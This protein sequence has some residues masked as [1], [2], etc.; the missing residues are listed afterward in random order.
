MG[1]TWVLSAPGG[2]HVGPMNLA[3][4]AAT[5]GVVT[6]RVSIKYMCYNTN[7]SMKLVLGIQY[8]HAHTHTHTCT[9]THIHTFIWT[10]VAS[11]L[12]ACI[13]TF[14]N[15]HIRIEKKYN[16]KR[17][18]VYIVR[19]KWNKN[20]VVIS[21]ILIYPGTRISIIT[22]L[23]V[24][25]PTRCHVPILTVWKPY[26]GLRGCPESSRENIAFNTITIAH[27]QITTRHR[28]I[29]WWNQ[30][31][32]IALCTAWVVGWDFGGGLVRVG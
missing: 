4:W 20:M 28:Q 13:R 2:P 7:L 17:T 10:P 11:L 12:H 15:K 3:I 8:M 14:H 21:N 32:L 25:D 19:K 30:I 22:W 1:S 24:S 6:V 26:S 27:Y 18:S 16:I 23:D 5:V 9:H 29:C 31:R